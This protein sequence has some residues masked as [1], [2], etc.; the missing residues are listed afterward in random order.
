MTR[1]A[2]DEALTKTVLDYFGRRGCRLDTDDVYRDRYL[3]DFSISRLEGVHAAVNLGVHVTS[4]TDQFERQETLLE[5]AR[6]GVVGRS[7]CIEF[8]TDDLDTGILPICFAA[9]VDYLFD[10]RYT[11][12]RAVG[13]RLFEDCTFH[14]FDLE[15]NV[16]RLRKDVHDAE[17]AEQ[18]E[19]TGR[20]IAYF[21]DK[22][23]GFIES[24][25]RGEREKFFFH[26][27]N[28]AEET[29][30]LDLPGYIQGDV[31]PV[32]FVYGGS[33][34]KKYPKAVDVVQDLEA[35]AET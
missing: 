9:C 27:A 3:I 21:A 26:I 19:R 33:E 11:H 2:G 28:V 23:F 18:V 4:E 7:I 20:I 34:G 10:R 15:D 31:I 30:R 16:R 35:D 5:A 29:L 8:V 17:H 22:G 14:F 25:D 24:H 13:L 6:K 32:H 12:T 1:S